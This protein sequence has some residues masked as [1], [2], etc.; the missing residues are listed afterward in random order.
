MSNLEIDPLDPH[1]GAAFD[2]FYDVY[3]AAERALGDIG[4]PW[5]RE[6][7]R[8]S[9]QD[10]GTRRWLG[11]Y[12]GRIDGDVVA[13][14]QLSTPLLDNRESAML[15]VHVDPRLWR[16]G[17]GT[18]VSQRLES[19][20]R[21]RGRTLL[22]TE[23]TWPYA[24]GPAGA[25]SP[26]P[27]F[28]LARGYALA[29]GD[30]KRRLELP[31]GDGVLD[32][33]TAEVVDHHRGYVLRSWVGPVPDDLLVGWARL[34]ASLVTEAPT[35]DLEIEQE[36]ADPAVVRESEAL[37]AKQGRTKYNTVALDERGEVVAYTD[38]ATTVHEPGVAYQWGTLVRGDARGHRLGLAVKVANLRL[39]QGERPD[40]RVLITYNA[41]V[42]RHMVGVNDRL[43][44]V[45]VARLGEFQKRL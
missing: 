12:V 38:I 1:D 20:A 22:N 9:L 14:G 29:I 16:R 17:L 10:R 32:D 13:V 11:A 43:G 18:Q 36:S 44:F 23:A 7:V 2:A 27:E 31:V 5:M 28:A 4:S 25:G 30:V 33:L 15:A 34:Y 3:L 6:E 42:N 37:L 40:V 21:E 39:L 35:G 8:A 45:P 41:E 24:A 19:E 26:G